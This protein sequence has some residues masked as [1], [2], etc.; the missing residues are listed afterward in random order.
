[1]IRYNL[2]CASGHEFEGWFSCSSDY[3]EQA[4]SGLLSCPVC[5]TDKVEKAIMAPAVKTA[6]KTAARAENAAKAMTEMAA[7]IRN[8]IGKNCENVGTDFAEEARAIH[9]GEKPERGIYGSATPPET[10]ALKEEGI[11]AHPLPDAFVPEADKTKL[12]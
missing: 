7:K 1:M 5:A 8:E 10:E 6:R 2:L 12:N 9:Y 4:K 11:T 3:D